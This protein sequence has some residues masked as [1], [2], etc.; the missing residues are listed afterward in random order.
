MMQCA[1]S[2][3]YS[4]SY[5]PPGVTPNLKTPNYQTRIQGIK[6]CHKFNNGRN[7]LL[8]ESTR[9]LPTDKSITSTSNPFVKHCVKLRQSSSYRHSHG[10]ALVVGTTLIREIHEFYNLKQVQQMPIEC[11]FL[12]DKAEIPEGISDIPGDRVYVSSL[13]MKKLSGVQSTESIEVIALMKMP[14]CFMTLNDNHLE[15]DCIRWFR[16]SG[17]HRILVLEGIQDPGNLGTLLRSALAF[18]WNGVFL[19][20]G[21]CDP[22]NEKALR[23]SRGAPFQLPLVSGN[24]AHVEAFCNEVKVKILAGHPDSSN[25]LKPVHKLSPKLA[26]SL[27]D[28]PL[29]LVLGSEGSGLTEKAR[30]FCEL[31]SIPMANNS[32]SLNVAVA[33]GIFMFMLQSELENTQT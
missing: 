5:R 13:V 15:M 1:N 2:H 12:L 26:Q 32:E 16:C 9:L 33:G 29:C 3:W 27:D 18:K 25:G 20:P 7:S 19:L 8:T 22:F 6:S 23:A 31:V 14:N 11:L 30:Q 4:T 17:T 21:C 28:T 24:W 10:S